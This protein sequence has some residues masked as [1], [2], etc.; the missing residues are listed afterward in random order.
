M[1]TN[2][3]IAY[4]LDKNPVPEDRE[5]VSSLTDILQGVV[6][7][8]FVAGLASTVGSSNTTPQTNNQIAALTKRVEELEGEV[9]ALT[10]R[11]PDR[12]VVAKNQTLVAGDQ[13]V[14]LTWSP[15]FDTTNYEVR[16][17]LQGGTAHPAAYYGWRVVESTKTTSSVQIIFDNLPANSSFSAVVETLE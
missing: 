7:F 8:G 14:A 3:S 1:A 16:V 15:P 4:Y 5:C 9:E 13:K 11:L 6:D 10:E 2:T 17:T 12:R